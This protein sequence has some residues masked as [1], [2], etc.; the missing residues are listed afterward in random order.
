MARNRR[1]KKEAP[2]DP[3]RSGALEDE[4]TEFEEAMAFYDASGSWPALS[5]RALADKT[6]PPSP[7]E[8]G[9]KKREIVRLDLHGH[10]F[11]EALAR[12]ERFLI[13]S[14]A[15]DRR[16]ALVITGRGHRS[17]GGVPVLRRKVGAWMRNQGKTWV[18]DVETA[19]KELGGDGAWLVHLRRHRRR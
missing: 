8:V 9:K 15:A 12:L 17:P 16:R 18:R 7:A 1:P 6:E 11:E 10:S 5:D 13:Q 4:D 2:P 19:P 14:T 3:D